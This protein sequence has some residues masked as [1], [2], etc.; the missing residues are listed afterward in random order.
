MTPP[1]IVGVRDLVFPGMRGAQ[2]SDFKTDEIRHAFNIQGNPMIW[3][4]KRK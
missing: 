1:T 3:H 2:M 4:D